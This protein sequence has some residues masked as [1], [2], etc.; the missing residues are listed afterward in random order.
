MPS[1]FEAEGHGAALQRGRGVCHRDLELHGVGHV[2]HHIW[3][4]Q[5]MS[6][7]KKQQQRHN[8]WGRRFASLTRPRI[9]HPAAEPRTLPR[10]LGKP[11]YTYILARIAFVLA[12]ACLAF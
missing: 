10:G 5:G 4:D 11:E 1:D 2:F 7:H 8:G 9:S 12:S 6:S 3:K